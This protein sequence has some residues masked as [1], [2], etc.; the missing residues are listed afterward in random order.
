MEPD[1]NLQKQ[2]A[3]AMIDR[4]APEQLS[5]VR[6]LLEV[7]LDPGSRAVA[8]AP[9]DDEPLTEEEEKALDEA[10]D[11]LRH[12]QGIPHEQVLT[13]LG[14]TQEEVD[15][16]REQAKVDV[17]NLDK[18][19]AMRILSALHRFAESGTGDLEGA[20]RRSGRTATM[21]RRL[22]DFFRVHRRRHY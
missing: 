6:G 1:L 15:N 5:A 11:W 22:P 13:E 7:M 3:H 12:N 2:Q 8:N 18:P 17:R 4:L 16:Y 20:S 10:R 19:T 14:I 21:N 9:F